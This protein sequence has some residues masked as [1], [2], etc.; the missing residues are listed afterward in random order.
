MKKCNFFVVLRNRQ[1]L[2]G[3]PDIDVHDIIKIN[4]HTI[5]A[6]QTRGSDNCFANM[7]AIQRDD[8]KQETVKAEKYCTNTDSISKY[9]NKS[10]PMVE[11]RLS[12]TIN[13][14]LSGPS[15]DS[16]KKRSTEITQ[17]LHKDFDE[18]FNGIGCFDGTFSLQLKL[19][20]KPYQGLHDVWHMHVKNPSRRKKKGYKNKT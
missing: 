12:E 20:S 2:L 4:I 13:Y 6:E 16:D 8:P 1:A 15:Y 18:V 5:G 17:Q 11:S 3:M 14:F 7:H 9:S 10:K 19:D